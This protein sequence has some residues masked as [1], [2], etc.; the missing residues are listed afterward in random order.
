[1]HGLEAAA[2]E[3]L[4][5]ARRLAGDLDSIDKSC[6]KDGGWTP[7]SSSAT[8]GPH[9]DKQVQPSE[10]E[11]LLFEAAELVADNDHYR[12]ECNRR[13]P[14]PA[15]ESELSKHE[16]NGELLQDIV[17]QNLTL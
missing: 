12:H 8:L 2:D 11:G 15:T 1:M 3:L 14:L 4:K 7:A 17:G 6:G 13:G 5:E 16:G 10:V 9:P